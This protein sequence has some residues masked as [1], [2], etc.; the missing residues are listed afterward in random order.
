MRVWIVFKGEG[1]TVFTNGCGVVL[2]EF[3]LRG[4]S[5]MR[6]DCVTL[7]VKVKT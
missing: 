3:R 1:A 4:A 6:V 2:N 7:T 5:Q